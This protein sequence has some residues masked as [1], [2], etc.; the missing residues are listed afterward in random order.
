M[1]LFL[2]IS[3]EETKLKNQIKNTHITKNR[4]EK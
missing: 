2:T 3:A 4:N 1:N